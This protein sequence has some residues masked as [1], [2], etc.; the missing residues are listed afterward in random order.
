MYNP[1]V[2]LRR[3]R[4]LALAGVMAAGSPLAWSKSLTPTP[5][6]TAGPF[7]PKTFPIDDD[8]DLTRVAGQAD[9]AKGRITDLSGRITDTRGHPLS[10]ARM[11]IWQCDANGRYHHPGDSRNVPL[12][13]NFQGHGH[14]LT[15]EEGEYRFRTIRPVRYPGRTPHIH[16]V[17]FLPGERPFVTQIYIEGE[18]GNPEDFLF[19]RIP[20][21]RRPLV[22]ADF[23]SSD[24]EGAE[25][26]A[27]FDIIIGTTPY[28]D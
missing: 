10:R 26:T 20:V 18:P 8:N 25:F 17:V 27:S 12:D 4:F 28:Q 9:S 11:E 1:M 15:D 7:Y 23:R 3:R 24:G 14:T 2:K 5:R 13:E 16:T 22:L 19:N 21:E 6:Q